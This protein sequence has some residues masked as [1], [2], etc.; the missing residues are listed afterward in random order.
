MG[1]GWLSP[2]CICLGA[3][4]PA[5]TWNVPQGPSLTP[6]RGVWRNPCNRN[7]ATVMRA[8]PVSKGKKGWRHFNSDFSVYMRQLIW[9]PAPW[10]TVPSFCITRDCP[11]LT[12]SLSSKEKSKSQCWKPTFSCQCQV[13]P[14]WTG[15]TGGASVCSFNFSR[16]P[17]KGQAA[18]SKCRRIICCLCMEDSLLSMGE[19]WGGGMKARPD[20]AFLRFL[21]TFSIQLAKSQFQAKYGIL[22]TGAA[23][24][25]HPGWAASYPLLHLLMNLLKV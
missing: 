22:P 12:V 6:W 23:A 18:H 9:K 7:T 3:Q 5:T 20:E 14:G 11:S 21:P 1:N 15:R 2:S 13:Y 16:A 17:I 10:N 24:R 19:A 4:G 8:C 25:P